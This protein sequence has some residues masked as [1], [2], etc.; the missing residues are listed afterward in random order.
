MIG[1]IPAAGRGT[2]AYPYTRGVPK[3]MLE[4][5]G[6]PNLA[7]VLRIMRDQL[8]ITEVVVVIGTYGDVITAHFGD[9]A[10]LG[11]RIRYVVN[12]ALD[13]GLSHSIL[14]SRPLVDGDFCVMLG[15]ERYVDSDHHV[16]LQ[17]PHRGH[18]ATCCAMRTKELER[19]ERNYGVWL[20]P[21]GRLER[22]VE[23]PRDPSGALLGVGTFLL[24]PEIY[25]HLQAAVDDPTRT[26]DDPVSVL[27]ALR[28]EGR[29]VSICELG[30][31]Y[32][33]I[34]DRDD[35]NLAAN[36]VRRAS[37]A[38]SSVG[39]VL[40][41]KG[42]EADTRRTIDEF[43]GARRFAEMLLVTHAGSEL[44]GGAFEG[45]RRVLAPSGEYGDMVRAGLDAAGTDIVITAQSDGSASPEDVPKFLEYLKDADYVIG[46]RTTRQLVE[47]G[48]NMRGI[49]R[50]A[51]VVLAKLCELVWWTYEPRFTDLGCA[52]RAL[53]RSHYRLIAP[54]LVTS[55]PEYAIESL[56][57]TL[58]SRKRLIEIPVN[59]RIRRKWL[60]EKDQTLRTFL[61]IVWL[62]VARRMRRTRR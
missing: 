19:I 41:G 55:G 60:R 26:A 42:S 18:L 15:D 45:V 13:K 10:Q 21:D 22:L 17:A 57:E 11:M 39:L 38:R 58:R 62:I 14:L 12:D 9:G 25:D 7:H 4:V 3:A 2:R 56:L 61:R 27:E 28:A 54:A 29:D 20:G 52:Y 24:S 48:T 59:F 46:T 6:E 31:R 16:L 32:V 50:A 53:W 51:H 35:L 44:A 5:A 36:L 43:A 40:L 47:Q 30:G 37:F 34:N 8:A 1:V 23:K 49:V 33:N